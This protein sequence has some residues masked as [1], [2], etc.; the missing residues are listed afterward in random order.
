MKINPKSDEELQSMNL[1]DPGIYSFEVASAKDKLSKSNNEMI[2]LYLK[3]WDINGHERP[4]YD[5]LLEAMG[6]KLKHFAECAGLLD[7]YEAGEIKAFDCVGRQGKLELIIQSGQK[8]PDGSSY[9]DKNSVKDYITSGGVIPN[10][11]KTADEAPFQDDINI[12]F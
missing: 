3:V 6:F 8:K 2:E 4:I 10:T 5:Y 1:I 11:A 7:K 9:A 12:P